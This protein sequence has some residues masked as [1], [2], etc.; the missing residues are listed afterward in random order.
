MA[1]IKGQFNNF[2]V[3]NVSVLKGIL[4]LVSSAAQHSGSIVIIGMKAGDE[5]VQGIHHFHAL[6]PWRLYRPGATR[7]LI[8][9]S[10][11]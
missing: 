9:R 4:Q 2:K 5:N 8:K 10:V 11:T 1:Y 6:E 7:W 3:T